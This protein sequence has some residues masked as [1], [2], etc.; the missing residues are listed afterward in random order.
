[1]DWREKKRPAA[2]SGIEIKE[3]RVL[4]FGSRTPD[5]HAMLL[6]TPRDE[7]VFL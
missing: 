5:A 3:D 7:K 4:K 6:P 1:V 2:S